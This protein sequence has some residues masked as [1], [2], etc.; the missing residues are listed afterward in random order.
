LPEVSG[1]EVGQAHQDPVWDPEVEVGS[2]APGQSASKHNAARDD[3]SVV[4]VDWKCSD[5]LSADGFKARRGCGEKGVCLSD[6][7]PLDPLW[8][9]DVQLGH[10]GPSGFGPYHIALDI[11]SYA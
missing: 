3:F 8:G 9:W 7:M 11:E 2:I 1:L 4:Y 5:F 10:I 6:D